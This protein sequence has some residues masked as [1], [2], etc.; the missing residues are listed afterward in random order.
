MAVVIN[1]FGGPGVG[2][3]VAMAKTFTDL[4]VR[5]YMVKTE[6]SR[7]TLHRE[8]LILSVS[9]QITMEVMFFHVH[10]QWEPT[11]L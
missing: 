7:Y 10:S 3:S 4:K 1:Y 8:E 5:G 6:M 9:I 2:K 11:L